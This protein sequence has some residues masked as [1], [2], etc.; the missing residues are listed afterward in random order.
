MPVQIGYITPTKLTGNDR[1]RVDVTKACVSK[2][3]L[4]RFPDGVARLDQ[5]HCCKLQISDRSGFSE[6]RQPADL[7]ATLKV[8]LWC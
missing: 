2:V 4:H 5:G 7:Q 1:K 6:I 8:G 3:F